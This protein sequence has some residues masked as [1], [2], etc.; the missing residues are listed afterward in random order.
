ML[1]P[2]VLRLSAPALD[3]IVNDDDICVDD[4][5]VIY[6][7]L[8]AEAEGIVRCVSLLVKGVKHYCQPFRT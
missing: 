2:A 1:L 8:L 3:S 7:M 4:Y 6:I 5:D